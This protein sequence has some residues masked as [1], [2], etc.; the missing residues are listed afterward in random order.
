[1]A[2]PRCTFGGTYCPNCVCESCERVRAGPTHSGTM[3]PVIPVEGMPE[4][5]TIVFVRTGAF[6]VDGFGYLRLWI[7][8]NTPPEC[9]ST[10]GWTDLGPVPPPMTGPPNASWE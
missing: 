7:D 3:P 1:M 8:Q 10:E 2:D 9:C 6:D 4:E 5:D